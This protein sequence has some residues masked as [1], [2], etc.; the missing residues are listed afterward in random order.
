VYVLRPPCF[1]HPTNRASLALPPLSADLKG[2]PRQLV[3]RAFRIGAISVLCCTS[4]L[5]ASVN[6]SARRVVFRDGFEGYSGSLRLWLT[7]TK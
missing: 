4:T 6:L 7:G 1:P 2:A 3:E 5:I